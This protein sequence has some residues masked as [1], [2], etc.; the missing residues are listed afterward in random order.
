MLKNIWIRLMTLCNVTLLLSLLVVPT[1]QANDY[2][3]AGPAVTYKPAADK[4]SIISYSLENGG[5]QIDCEWAIA[6]SPENISIDSIGN[7]S[8]S[9]VFS[10]TS[11]ELQ[12][13][14]LGTTDILATLTVTVKDH[15]Y[16]HFQ[17]ESANARPNSSQSATWST[18]TANGALVAWDGTTSNKFLNADSATNKRAYLTLA[19]PIDTG[20]V[21]LEMRVKYKADT[22]EGANFIS[23]HSSGAWMT[24]ISLRGGYWNSSYNQDISGALSNIKA[25]TKDE[26]ADVKITYNLTNGTYSVYIDSEAVMSGFKLNKN[27]A[28]ATYS[29]NALNIR[30]PID[31]VRIYSG[32]TDPELDV[33]ASLS[34]VLIPPTG[35]NVSVH[36][37]AQYLNGGSLQSPCWE[38]SPSYQGV[39]INETTGRINVSGDA[40]PGTLTVKLTDNGSSKSHTIEMRKIYY[41]FVGGTDNW[42]GA[43]VEDGYMK[44]EGSKTATYTF[45]TT[46]E[47]AGRIV[48]SAKLRRATGGSY[49]TSGM[50]VTMKDT[51]GTKWI[52]A[53]TLTESNGATIFR[54][55]NRYYYLPEKARQGDDWSDYKLIIDQDAKTY[56]V[57]FN[58]EWV[59]EGE[60]VFDS[61]PEG[62]AVLNDIRLRYDVDDFAIYHAPSNLPE[63][64]NPKV[65]NAAV[66]ASATAEYDFIDQAGIQEECSLYEWYISDTVNGNYSRIDS[67]TEKAYI[68]SEEQKGKYIKFVVTPMN[69]EGYQGLAAES[70][71]VLISG[72]DIT[73]VLKINDESV[74]LNYNKYLQAGDNSISLEVQ[75]VNH[76]TVGDEEP[77][78]VILAI[79][80]GNTLI[81]VEFDEISVQSGA[82][83]A[84]TANYSL[85]VTDGNELGLYKVKC[86]LWQGW[87]DITPYAEAL[88]VR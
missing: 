87:D 44:A 35:Q 51:V 42:S 37:S 22:T 19:A 29:L 24:D 43:S 82:Y 20:I 80:K 70:S 61:A 73:S 36:M 30:V 57:A 56:M 53:Q 27:A 52:T 88:S 25:Q 26:W 48:I 78:V 75:A 10:E 84:A 34:N 59:S 38:I 33:T 65:K 77:L 69:T 40:Q 3:I 28:D 54:D 66:G 7:V 8:L 50:S 6:G 17:S 1:V 68:P 72:L 4:V 12:A 60:L 49:L 16:F 5:S 83:D 85:N 21:T 2:T 67:A 63:A 9:G 11:F 86:M 62:A 15:I 23:V 71:P 31:D 64:V 58:G 76:Q 18:T 32:V 79:Y 46:Y 39:S 81:D 74:S 14:G 47:I 13:I 55:Y 45:P 41:D